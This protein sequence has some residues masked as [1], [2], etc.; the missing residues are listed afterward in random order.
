M[1][2]VLIDHRP[3]GGAGCS[4]CS[5]L[6]TEL[7]ETTRRVTPVMPR[8]EV[9]FM[10]ARERCPCYEGI[11]IN[12]GVSQCTHAGHADG[13]EFCEPDSCPLVQKEDGNA[14]R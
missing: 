12:A 5:E 14:D 13:G 4:D 10:T 1:K 2:R 11:S 9:A 8:D 7:V 3:C 6:G